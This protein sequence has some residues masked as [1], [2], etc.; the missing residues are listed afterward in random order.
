M[1]TVIENTAF[2]KQDLHKQIRIFSLQ[3]CYSGE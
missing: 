1:N 2:D 3:K